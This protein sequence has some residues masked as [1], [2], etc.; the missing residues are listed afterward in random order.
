MQSLQSGPRHSIGRGVS[1][2]QHLNIGTDLVA[3]LTPIEDA[4]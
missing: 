4:S 3:K 1:R 2:T